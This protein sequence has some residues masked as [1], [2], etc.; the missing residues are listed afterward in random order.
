MQQHL[1]SFVTNEIHPLQSKSFFTR[2]ELL[3][4]KNLNH[5]RFLN[6]NFFSESPNRKYLCRNEGK[7]KDIHE[8]EFVS[9]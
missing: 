7:L 6:H 5:K 8:G 9:K 1:S 3:T 2:V 4:E